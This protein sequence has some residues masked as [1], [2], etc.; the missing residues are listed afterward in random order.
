VTS[1]TGDEVL[2]DVLS[3][4][5]PAAEGILTIDEQRAITWPCPRKAKSAPWTAADSILLDE[6]SAFLERPTTFM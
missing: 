2:A 1:R 4:P 6:V 5:T 3:D